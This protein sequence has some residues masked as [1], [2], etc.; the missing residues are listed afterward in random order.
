MEASAGSATVFVNP[1]A[2]GGQATRIAARVRAAFARAGYAAQF[3]EPRCVGDFRG[4]VR[5]AISG[6]CKTLIAMGGDGTLQVLVREALQCPVT[7]G[8]IPAGGGNDFAEALGIR[9]WQH[10]AQVIT[11][12][13][14]RAVDL[15]R[16][17]FKEGSAIYLGG[18]GVG[19]DAEAAR[20]ASE[21]FAKWR[22]RLRYLAAAVSALRGFP[23]IEVELGFPADDMPAA[24]GKVLLAAVLNTPSYGGGL[25][26]APDAPL[27]DGLAEVVLIEMLS[28]WQ[29]ASVIPHLMLTGELKTGR[30][31]RLRASRITLN[32]PEKTWFHGDGELLG[33]D[34][35]EISVLPKAM[36]ILAP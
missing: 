31:Q 33:Q 28:K 11:L 10:A 32:T 27:D 7:F 3:R 1:W 24:R 16:V 26:L 13:R 9:N 25:R 6:G 17:Q 29:V 4:Q 2:G 5:A 34:A 36:R 14:T 21:R 8:I 20:L 22:G 15:M 30:V 19:L 12:G 35:R 23:G 18:G